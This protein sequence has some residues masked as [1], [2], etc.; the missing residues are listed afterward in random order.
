M[1][2]KNVN[3]H[4]TQN[5]RIIHNYKHVKEI[6]NFGSKTLEF[7]FGEKQQNM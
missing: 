6:K 5:A 3:C 2:Y 4:L 1:P 7:P